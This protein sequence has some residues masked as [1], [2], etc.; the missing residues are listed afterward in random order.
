MSAR[1]NMRTSKKS[2]CNSKDLSYKNIRL[3]PDSQSHRLDVIVF[4]GNPID[5]P[6]CRHAGLL[7]EKMSHEGTMMQRRFLHVTGAAGFFLREE[8]IDRDP[9]KSEFF[10][11][12]VPV[13][14]IPASGPS[15]SRL[16][17]AIWFTAINNAEMG[18]NCHNWVGDA[19]YAC[20]QAGLVSKDKTEKAIEG[21]TDLIVQAR[22]VV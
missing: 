20:T 8:D 12:S 22:D 9:T 14:T 15:D 13:A 1:R 18:W 4:R 6:C 10:A 2:T 19:L 21:M 7:I 5:S 17:D 3:E 16:R 11:G